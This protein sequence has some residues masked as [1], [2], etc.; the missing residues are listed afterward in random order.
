MEKQEQKTNQKPMDRK[1]RLEDCR[2]VLKTIFVPVELFQTVTVPILAAVNT[3]SDII[4]D[5]AKEEA[6]GKEEKAS[7]DDPVQREDAE[8]EHD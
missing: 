5:M 4:N 7:A 8:P 6:E 3:L 2:N 1:K